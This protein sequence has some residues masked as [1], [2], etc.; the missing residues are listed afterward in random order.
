MA[1]SHTVA[2]GSGDRV[3]VISLEDRRS[4]DAVTAWMGMV[5]F[6]ASWAVMFASLFYIY[7]GVRSRMPAWPP[8]DQPALPLGLPGV[9]GGVAVLASGAIVLA[10]RWLRRGD[11]RRGAHALLVAAWLAAVFLGLQSYVWGTLWRDGLQPDGGPYGSVFYALTGFHALHVL[12]GLVAL[13]ALAVRASRG[14]LGAAASLPVRL[15]GMYWHFVGVVWLA[16]YAIVYV[17]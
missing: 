7:A 16:I 12:V 4:G 1:A 2:L 17:A 3:P 9:N 5:F 14:G 15:W 11:G 10:L 8:L 13:V 6:L